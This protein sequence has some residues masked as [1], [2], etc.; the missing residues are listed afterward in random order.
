[1]GTTSCDG[2]LH[3]PDRSQTLGVP[4]RTWLV[5]LLALAALPVSA[6]DEGS[7]LDPRLTFHLD[8]APFGRLAEAIWRQT[9]REV[10][11]PTSLEFGRML[12]RPPGPDDLP[13]AWRTPA[14]TPVP[15]ELEPLVPKLSIDVRGAT[16]RAVL[17]LLGGQGYDVQ[18]LG[19]GIVITAG[20]S[21]SNPRP[22]DPAPAADGDYPYRVTLV[23][24]STAIERDLDAAL[25]ERRVTRLRY[26]VGAETELLSRALL[27]VRM[28][29]LRRV[30]DVMAA[31]IV[32]AVRPFEPVDELGGFEYAVPWNG[33][34]LTGIGRQMLAVAWCRDAAERTYDFD[35]TGMPGQRVEQPGAAVTLE[36]V[37]DKGSNW[38]EAAITVERPMSGPVAY[39]LARARLAAEGGPRRQTAQLPVDSRRPADDSP[40]MDVSASGIGGIYSVW[41]G[42]GDRTNAMWPMPIL[43]MAD[44]GLHRRVVPVPA[45]TGACTDALAPV[46]LLQHGA[47]RTAMAVGL[48]GVSLDAAQARV[49]LRYV[50]RAWVAGDRPSSLR[51]GLV[52]FGHDIDYQTVSFDAISLPVGA[53]TTG[54]TGTSAREV[55]VGG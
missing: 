32:S 6:A 39:H 22:G 53:S 2:R 1:M 12:G 38:V 11:V 20:T 43:G 49:T 5:A 47:S 30:G 7:V 52:D 4:M 24:T 31:G 10:I 36:R 29:S 9:G 41:D 18:T 13:T 28:V 45:W 33:T 27:G 35:P 21:G 23:G 40:V 46:V 19:G 26:R 17:N 14:S 50:A 48:C 34:A 15:A 44:D 37:D 55:P 42:D 3:K 16:L 8:Q 25:P 51:V 54:L